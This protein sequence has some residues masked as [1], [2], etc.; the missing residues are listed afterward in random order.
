MRNAALLQKNKTVRFLSAAERI[1]R[2]LAEEIETAVA[3]GHAVSLLAHARTE[4]VESARAEA[5]WST[6]SLWALAAMIAKSRYRD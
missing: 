3:A 2:E 6:F 4:G 1:D 5:V